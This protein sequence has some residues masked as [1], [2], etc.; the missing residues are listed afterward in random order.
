MGGLNRVLYLDLSFLLKKWAS[1][2]DSITSIRT[3]CSCT[4]ITPQNLVNLINQSLH[5]SSCVPETRPSR[6]LHTFKTLSTILENLKINMSSETNKPPI[7]PRH[8]RLSPIP[9]DVRTR[10]NRAP[11][12]HTHTHNP[13]AEYDSQAGPSSKARSHNIPRPQIQV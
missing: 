1:L 4:L 11:L 10:A 7:R 2:Q 3:W 13:F 9:R 5:R 6:Q 8:L 12:P